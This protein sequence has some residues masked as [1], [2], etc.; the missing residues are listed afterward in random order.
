M[1]HEHGTSTTSADRI[2]HR[3]DSRKLGGSGRVGHELEESAKESVDDS[4]DAVVFVRAS[5]SLRVVLRGAV[6]LDLGKGVRDG[7]RL[8]ASVGPCCSLG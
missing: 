6:V 2:Y 8:L 7:S 1:G 5:D 3:V 4:A